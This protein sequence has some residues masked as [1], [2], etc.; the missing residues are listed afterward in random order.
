ME[1]V[2]VPGHGSGTLDQLLDDPFPRMLMVQT[3]SRCN[4]SCVFCPHTRFRGALPRGEMVPELFLRLM[5]EAG[6]HAVSC[7]NLFLMNEPLMDRELVRR[8]FLARR[9][10]PR[11][12]VSL[13][14]N[15]VALEAPLARQLLDSP[16]SSIGFSLHA[17]HPETYRRLTG[18]RD[19]DRVLRQVV[20]FVEQR[21]ARRPEMTVVLRYVSANSMSAGEQ[22]ALQAFWADGAVVLD[23]DPGHLSRAGNLPAPGAPAA[24]HRRMAGCQALGGPKQAHILFTGQVVLC[25]MDYGHLTSLGNCATHTLQEIWT[26]PERRV[27][28]EMLYG[29]RPAAPDF[30]CRR[31]ELAIAGHTTCVT[32]DPPDDSVWAAA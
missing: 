9:F 29:R 23:I 24:P 28:L 20:H 12:Q 7:I 19:F 8:I 16:L 26:G 22:E 2:T 15:G 6:H 10:N 13:W 18:R 17:H 30:L 32:P 14:T 31:C 3:T 5:A 27:A 1:P 21:N 4:S 25:C 11:A